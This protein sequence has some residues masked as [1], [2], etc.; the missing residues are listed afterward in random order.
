MSKLRTSILALLLY[1]SSVGFADC[2]TDPLKTI[3]D[4]CIEQSVKLC[5]EQI[6]GKGAT[7]DVFILIVKFIKDSVNYFV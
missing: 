6:V 3:T 1:V 2:S 5:E 7:R 4:V